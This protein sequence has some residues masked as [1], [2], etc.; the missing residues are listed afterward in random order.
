MSVAH[1]SSG[2]PLSLLF[3][4]IS[5]GKATSLPGAFRFL[6]TKLQSCKTVKGL[7]CS[8][9]SP[10]YPFLC[11]R[12]NSQSTSLHSVV[13]HTHLDAS[14]AN[15]LHFTE[16]NSYCC[17]LLSHYW[18]ERLSQARLGKRHLHFPQALLSSTQP[19]M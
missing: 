17:H 5:Y 8:I 4:E 14:T 2:L 10:C 16:H 13:S 1:C 18:S 3:P 11:M 12:R 15:T 9:S 19:N 6:C 7:N